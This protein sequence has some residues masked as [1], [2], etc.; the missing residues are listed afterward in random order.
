MFVGPPGSRKTTTLNYSIELFEGIPDLVAGPNVCSQ[1]A[2]SDELSKSHDTSLYIISEDFH[3]LLMKSGGEMYEFLTSAFDGRKKFHTV[4]ISRKTEY[5]EKPCINFAAGSTP[6]WISENMPVSAIGGGFAARVIF[7]YEETL[8]R[9]KLDY[10]DVD[11]AKMDL[12]KADLQADLRHISTEVAGEFLVSAEVRRYAELQYL[13]IESEK[14]HPKVQGYYTRKHVHFLKLAML[15]NISYSDKLILTTDDIDNA[16]KILEVT[17]EQNLTR[18]FEGVGKN[19]YTFDMRD[20]VNYIKE[21]QRVSRKEVLSAFRSVATPAMVN[22]LIL[23]LL[24]TGDLKQEVVE[25]EV[26]YLIV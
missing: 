23:G 2:L 10:S 25:G 12:L 13:K 3:D 14:H 16:L 9:K 4:T 22:E 5:M 8:R 19:I 24:A 6:V 20:I 15:L 21:K 17:V 18:V 26:Y 7:I 1:A 11:M